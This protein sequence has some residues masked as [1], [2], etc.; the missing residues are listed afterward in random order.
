MS[1]FDRRSLLILPL[2]LAACGFTPVYG[3]GGNG[4]ALR[5][6]VLVQEP[7]S[8]DEYIL[9]RRLED[10]LGRAQAP[11]YDLSYTLATETE[12][13]AVTATNETTRYSL[14]GR[15]DYVLTARDGGT[16]VASGQVSNFTG[17]SAT[18]TTVETLA[19]ERDARERL[20]AILA[21]QLV[22]RLYATA[23]LPE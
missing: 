5:G 11:A 17:Y 20:M 3:P 7:D 12:G 1:S 14:V 15:L 2:A 10:S 19:G 8:P 18:G 23:D 13:Q 6:L 21:D 4:S 22:T 9:V 16:V